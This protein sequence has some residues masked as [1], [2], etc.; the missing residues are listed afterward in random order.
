[1]NT[2]YVDGK[3]YPTD[4]TGYTQYFYAGLRSAGDLDFAC[5]AK[6]TSDFMSKHVDAGS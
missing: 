1:M 2:L 4:V 6:F 3:T 5:T